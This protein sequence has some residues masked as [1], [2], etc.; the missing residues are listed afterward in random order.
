MATNFVNALGAGSGIDTQQLAKD[1][2]EATREP[3]KAVIDEKIAKSEARISGYG[4]IQFSLGELKTAF[5]GLNDLSDFASLQ[6]ANT[7]ASAL[8]VVA[9]PT[10]AAG[11]YQVN[12][13]Q[14]A[15]AQ[16]T[17]SDGFAERSTALNSGASFDLTLSVNGGTNQ[18]ITVDTDTPAGVVAAIN[19]AD[20]GITAQLIQTSGTTPWKIVVTGEEGEEQNFT[21]SAPVDLGFDDV[22]NE[23]QAAQNALLTVNGLSIERTTNSVSDVIDGVTFNLATITSGAARIDLTRDTSGITQ[24]IEDLVTAYNNFEENLKILGDRTSEVEEFGGV[25]AG[26]S[27]LQNIRSQVR[28]M[29]TST[30]STPG[31]TVTAPRDVGLSFDRYGVLQFDQDKLATQLQS[32]FDEVAQMFSANT[33]NQSV[34]SVADAGVAGDAVKA[35]D[36]MMRSTGLIAQQTDNATKQV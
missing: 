26:D 23:L 15:Q 29:L 7:Q 22:V 4:V 35:I 21:L 27:L 13:T 30:S 16:R 24:K 9:S 18:T 25:L 31:S 19:G 8:G 1:L 6:V 32:N 12:V 28:A 17:A 3:R 34:Y 2:M 14:V 36:E 11:S 33:N 10:A 20:L 5:S